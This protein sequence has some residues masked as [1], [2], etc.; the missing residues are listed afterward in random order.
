MI[1]NELYLRTRGGRSAGGGDCEVMFEPGV[2]T[3]GY[4]DPLLRTY[5]L[6]SA[7]DEA[8][9]ESSEKALFRARRFQ[10]TTE[11]LVTK[12][13]ASTLSDLDK[14]DENLAKIQERMGQVCKT[15]ED[16]HDE[17][18]RQV[19]QLQGINKKADKVLL[20]EHKAAHRATQLL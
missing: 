1:A 15:T 13:D 12:A 2:R 18:L 9:M 16:I 19:G 17:G 4:G 8:H 11:D 10:K 14:V 3:F 7:L 20:D 5:A 6:E